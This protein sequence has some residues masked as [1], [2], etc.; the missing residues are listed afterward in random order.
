[1]T[2]TPAAAAAA[3]PAAAQQATRARR[4]HMTGGVWS[5]MTLRQRLLTLLTV[6]GL[7]LAIVAITIFSSLQTLSDRRTT[8]IDKLDPAVLASRDLRTSL[9][10]Q[11]T[12]IRG[13]ILTGDQRFLQDYNRGVEN[14][15]TAVLALDSYLQG[16]PNLSGLR[17]DLT[18]AINTWERDSASQAIAFVPTDSQG[19]PCAADPPNPACDPTFLVRSKQQFDDV[20]AELNQADTAIN[21]E[22]DMAVDDFRLAYRNLTIL[23]IIELAGFVI[24]GALVAVA[25]SRSVSRPVEHLADQV[26]EVAAGN[27][28]RT[29]VGEGPPELV[30]LGDDT[31]LMRERILRE[32]ELLNEANDLLAQQAV[33]LERSNADLEQF[34]YVASHDLQEPLRKVAGFCQLLEKRYQGELDERADQYIFFAVDGAKRMQDLINDLLAFSRVGRTTDRFVPVRL[35]DA[36]AVGCENLGDRVSESDATINAGPLPTVQGDPRLLSAVFQNLVGNA[37]K[38]RSDEPPIITIDSTD[39]DGMWTVSVSDNGTGIEPQYA[40]QIFTLFQRLHNKA[41][42]PGTGIGLSLCKKIVEFHG[43]HIWLDPHQGGGSTF[44]FTLPHEGRIPT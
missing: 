22:R 31:N 34:A 32:I 35:D 13:Y 1:M 8:V 10:D 41:E 27:L 9:I 12:G 3:T 28:S 7:F 36:L 18:N 19:P 25:L 38:F 17:N 21:L 15:K 26:Q 42:Y 30:N 33:E 2:A 24:L 5:R 4:R 16:R 6:S 39:G 44:R 14:E 23:P 11:E 20:R 40:D 43:G 37:I 29:I